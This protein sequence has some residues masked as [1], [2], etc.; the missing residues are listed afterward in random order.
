MTNKLF[1]RFTTV[2]LILTS[3]ALILSCA[4]SKVEV[5]DD[6]TA[7]EL[8]QKAQESYDAGNTKLAEQYYTILLQ[9]FGTDTSVYVE[10]RYELAHLYAKAKNYKDAVP[11]LQEIISIYENSKPGELPGAYHKLAENELKRIPADKVKEFTKTVAQ[12]TTAEETSTEST[13]TTVPSTETSSITTDSTVPFTK[14]EVNTTENIKEGP[15]AQ[16]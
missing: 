7:R 3:A 13:A 16:N 2:V 10:G 8:V 9:R 14:P 11:M 4:S 15:S 1:N 5:A 6:I 12:E